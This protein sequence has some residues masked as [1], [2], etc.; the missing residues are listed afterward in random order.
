MI[1]FLFDTSPYSPR[2]LCGH[3]TPFIGWTHIIS[4]FLIFF[5]Y[6]CIPV[7]LLY[8]QHKIKA[9][10]INYLFY[11]FAAFIFLCGSTHLIEVI[12][13]WKPIYNFAGL[14]KLLTALVS[15]GTLLAI[16][17]ILPTTLKFI[18]EK[19]DTKLLKLELESH[20]AR[21]AQEANLAKDRF[22]ASMSHELRTPLNAIIG[23]TGTLLM[24]L[25]GPINFEQEKQLK[26]IQ[27][28]SK[29]LLSLIND[30][31][32]LSKVEA[33]KFEFSLTKTNCTEIIKD[34][35]NTLIPLC[36]NKG[37]EL[38]FT[39]SEKDIFILS[40]QRILKQII[41]NLVNNA[42]KFTERGKVEIKTQILK[43][44]NKEEIVIKVIDSGIGIKNDDK[45]KL[46]QAFE[47]IPSS[48]KMTEGT[49]L[50]LHL[51]QKLAK[52]INGRIDFESS[53]GHGSCFSLT[54]ENKQDNIHDSTYPNH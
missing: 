27:S 33:G 24:K 42:I 13:F 6:I 52:L 54:L 32:D 51:S 31:L 17:V 35:V 4:D 5:A 18:K 38:K 12:I 26:I 47:Q 19:L 49:G 16:I 36:N 37:L 2:W 1:D 15:L 30:I 44:L 22:L 9:I 3:W 39:P 23:Y 46:F 48:D 50:G 53:Y 20:K 45:S 25:P 34:V 28:S 41:I 40:D 43:Q 7:S 14:I 11:L 10:E 21:E 8:Y 29:H